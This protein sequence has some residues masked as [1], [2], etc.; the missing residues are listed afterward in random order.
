M[1]AAEGTQAAEA[2]KGG[3]MAPALTASAG[4]GAPGGRAASIPL[5]GREAEPTIFELSSPGRRGWSFR[6]T[7]AN[8]WRC[9]RDAKPPYFSRKMMRAFV[10]S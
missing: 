9:L 4:V 1:T 3:V 10:R 8:V 2:V 5:L 6:S 7:P